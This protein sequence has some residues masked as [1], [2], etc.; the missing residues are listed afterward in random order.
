M[1]S[2]TAYFHL[3]LVSD[4]TGETLI[5]VARAA[6]A[7]YTKR[8]AGRA[9]LSAGAHAEAARPR[10]GRDRGSAGHRALHAARGRSDRAAGGELPRARPALPVDP[11][12]GAAAVPVLSRRRDRR[13]RVGAQHM[14]NAEYF[15]RI[16]ALNYTMLHDDGQHVEDLEEADVVLVGVSRTSKTP[17]S[18]YLANRGVKTGNVPL[19]PGIAVPPQVETLAAAAGGRAVRQPGAHRADPAEPAARPQG[20]SRRRPV[21]RSQGGGRG[22]RV[23]APALR[24]AQLA[25]DRRDA[26][27]DRGDRGRGASSCWPSAAGSRSH[28]HAA[29]ARRPSRWC[30][31]RRAPCGARC[32]EAAG[33]PLEIVPADI[34]ER[35]IERSAGAGTAADRGACWRARRRGPS[36][37]RMPGRLVLGA[38]QTLALGDARFTKPADRAAAREQ[39]ATLARPDPRAAFGGRARARR[40]RSLFEHCRRRRS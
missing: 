23:L 15:K 14:L 18:I 20:A 31:P 25:D 11:R 27:L 5:T 35:A 1:R 9:R 17:T 38:D 29:L 6:A 22:G 7:Q 8:V 16:D 13:H 24:Q 39:L 37:P 19:V 2:C 28:E 33:I 3:H 21:Y 36:P 34:D 26:P 12:A 4:A 30:W 10:A 32:C 40:R